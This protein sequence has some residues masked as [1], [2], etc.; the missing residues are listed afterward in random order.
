MGTSHPPRL[1]KFI[2]RQL[3]RVHTLE[4]LTLLLNQAAANLDNRTCT[5]NTTEDPTTHQ[6]IPNRCISTPLPNFLIYSGTWTRTIS[7]K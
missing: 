5:K 6:E 7:L 1:Q 3:D 2:Q 4:A